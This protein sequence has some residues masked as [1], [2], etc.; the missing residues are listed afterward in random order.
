MGGIFASGDV[1]KG[2]LRLPFQV[3]EVM[4]GLILFFLIGGERLM[5]YRVRWG[6]RRA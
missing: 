4:N 6:P 1:V 2:V 3:V 5:Y